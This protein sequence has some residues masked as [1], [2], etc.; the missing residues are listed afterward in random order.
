MVIY[1][2][3]F[4]YIY[5][6]FL[7]IH[8]YIYIFFSIY[9]YI[10]YVHQNNYREI[11]QFYEH[12]FFR[13]VENIVKLLYLDPPGAKWMGVGVPLNN[14][15]GGGVRHPLE[16][17]GNYLKP[18]NSTRFFWFSWW[19]L[20]GF[21]HNLFYHEKPHHIWGNTYFWLGWNHHPCAL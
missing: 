14:P 6:Y 21:Y 17:A 16:G 15:L 1:I 11:I 19:F 5:I 3:N 7:N 9:I 13:W 20:F 8:I 4:N 10:L 2:Y 12:I 18:P